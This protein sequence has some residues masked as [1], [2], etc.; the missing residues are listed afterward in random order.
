MDNISGSTLFDESPNGNDGTINGPVSVPGKIGNALSFD[1]VNDIVNG[2]TMPSDTAISLCFWIKTTESRESIILESS[3]NYNVNPGAILSVINGSGD[4]NRFY[5]GVKKTTVGKYARGDVVLPSLHDG[6]YHFIAL[7]YDSSTAVLDD[8][9]MIYFDG[10]K[11]VLDF[12]PASGFDDNEQLPI[13]SESIYLGARFGGVAACDHDSDQFWQF[14]R[15]LT[16]SE[17]S[18]LYNGGV[19]V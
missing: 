6:N 1:G 3:S 19:G 16:P 12:N 5:F 14:N 15:V 2:Y 17:I 8:Q 11:Q 10:I 9:V 18:E 13:S 4:F 7:I